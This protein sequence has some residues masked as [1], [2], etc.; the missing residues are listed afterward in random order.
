MQLIAR[1][2]VRRHE[3]ADADHG[4][5]RDRTVRSIAVFRVT[6]A[7]PEKARQALCAEISKTA[8][9]LVALAVSSPE[10]SEHQE[11]VCQA[12]I[13]ECRRLA[14]DAVVCGGD[15]ERA[16]SSA[17]RASAAGKWYSSVPGMLQCLGEAHSR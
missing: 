4:T 11:A 15:P 12:V 2:A 13:A 6:G 16:E 14:A 1:M 7:S 9:L 10:V 5:R 3:M 8:G 17:S